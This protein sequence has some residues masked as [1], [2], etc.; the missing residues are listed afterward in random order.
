MLGW[1]FFFA[2]LAVVYLFWNKQQQARH[3]ASDVVRKHCAMQDLQLLDDTLILDGFSI[4]KRKGGGW[5]LLR[6]YSFEFSST[7]DERYRGMIQLAGRR[8]EQLEL[9]T[10]RMH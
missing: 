3:L 6:C 8:V 1:I 2:I 4:K 7:G 5:L 10:H 9:D